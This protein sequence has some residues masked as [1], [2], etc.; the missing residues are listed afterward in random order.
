[1][2]SCVLRTCNYRC[3]ASDLQV[4]L[5]KK[6]SEAI[7]FLA[8]EKSYVCATVSAREQKKMQTT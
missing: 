3:L 4:A 2:L 6:T 5:L 8:R 1:M 7:W